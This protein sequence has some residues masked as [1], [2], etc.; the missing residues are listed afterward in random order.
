MYVCLIPIPH[1]RVFQACVGQ[2]LIGCG[3]ANIRTVCSIAQSQALDGEPP[4]AVQAFASLGAFAKTSS[5]EERDLHRWLRNLH[6]IELEVY[7]TAFNVQVIW[8]NFSLSKSWSYK[9]CNRIY[10]IMGC[11]TMPPPRYWILPK[12][13]KLGS[14]HCCH[15]KFCMPCR[16]LARSR[17]GWW[18]ENGLSNF[19]WSFFTHNQ[20][21]NVFFGG[22]SIWNIGPSPL[23]FAKSMLGGMGPSALKHFWD[24]FSTIDDWMHHPVL[25]RVE[26][27][28]RQNLSWLLVLY[29]LVKLNRCSFHTRPN[30]LKW[31]LVPISFHVDGAEFYNNSEFVVW[32]MSSA[33]C[34]HG[35]AA[36]H[37]V[38]T[39]CFLVAKYQLIW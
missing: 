36:R 7:H 21:D 18:F 2:G 32:S 35:D 33:M 9:V 15:M 24:H 4:E 16:M 19:S 12:R 5:H 28:S 8:P 22:A 29:D 39:N 27:P 31:G 6:N 30:M 3:K 13:P 10:H 25:K 38:I 23:Q 34:A 17:M 11:A 20:F 14:Q 26:D 37:C 1:I